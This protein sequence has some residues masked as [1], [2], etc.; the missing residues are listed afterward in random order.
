MILLSPYVLFYIC[1]TDFNV[2][3]CVYTDR[4][5][6]S[7]LVHSALHTNISASLGAH[8]L[9][10]W[11]SHAILPIKKKN[12][13][14]R[15]CRPWNITRTLHDRLVSW[16]SNVTA[17]SLVTRYMHRAMY[18]HARYTPSTKAVYWQIKYHRTVKHINLQS[19]RAWMHQQL[20]W[21]K[22]TNTL[23]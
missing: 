9:I 6:Q 2:N 16:Q 22:C 4:C 20:G 14:N 19:S 7:T 11:S 5:V 1:K 18:S 10:F 12:K 3:I 17:L 23:L 21:L 13:H 15:L 8:R